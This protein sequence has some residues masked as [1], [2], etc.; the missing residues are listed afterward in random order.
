MQCF[1]AL[2]RVWRG[3]MP[4]QEASSGLAVRGGEEHDG[5]AALAERLGPDLGQG[6]GR[7][8]LSAREG[9]VAAR[10]ARVAEPCA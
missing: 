10:L 6:G 2:T 5:V 7:R 4:A 3:A 9:H 1:D 8:T